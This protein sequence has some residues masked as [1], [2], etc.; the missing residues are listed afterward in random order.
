MNGD[1]NSGGVERVVYYLNAILGEKYS[2]SILKR[3]GKPGKFDKLI[4]PLL[5]SLRLLF[6]RDRGCDFEFLAI[7]FVSG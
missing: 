1:D 6:K 3:K 7:F 5:F 2:V 4:F